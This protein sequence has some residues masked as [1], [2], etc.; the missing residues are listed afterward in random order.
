[1]KVP[2]QNELDETFRSDRSI[3]IKIGGCSLVSIFVVLTMFFRGVQSGRLD[4]PMTTTRYVV[5][6]VILGVLGAICGLLLSLKDTIAHR[7]DRGDSV[8]KILRLYFGRER[9]SLVV[10]F[11][12]ALVLAMLVTTIGATL[13]LF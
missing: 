10:W 8:N 12:S 6:A 9:L 11:A 3:W 13:G 1:M 4:I 5:M 2:F 7:I